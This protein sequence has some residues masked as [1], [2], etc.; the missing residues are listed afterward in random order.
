MGR[1]LPSTASLQNCA[2]FSPNPQRFPLLGILTAKKLAVDTEMQKANRG[3]FKHDHRTHVLVVQR[4]CHDNRPLGLESIR[5]ILD[6]RRKHLV[7]FPL[8]SPP[9]PRA[10]LRKKGQFT[11]AFTLHPCGGGG[12]FTD[13]L[14]AQPGL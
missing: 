6:P 2:Y 1:A 9:L 3:F 4:N 8:L 14:P 7:F 5:R 13:L 12:K 10:P 11:K